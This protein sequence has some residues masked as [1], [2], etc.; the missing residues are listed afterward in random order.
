LFHQIA[1]VPPESEQVSES[2]DQP[3]IAISMATVIGKHA[4]R[5][6]TIQGKLYADFGRFY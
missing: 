5:Y 4:P 6:C 2:A 1:E 3:L